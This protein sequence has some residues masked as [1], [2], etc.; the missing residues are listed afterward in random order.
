MTA[1]GDEILPLRSNPLNHYQMTTEQLSYSTWH[2]VQNAIEKGHAT[3]RG[4]VAQ[5][6]AL[7][8]EIFGQSSFVE[9][10]DTEVQRTYNAIFQFLNP[11]FRSK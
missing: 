10:V 2:D 11:Q 6:R 7:K 4:V 3:L 8:R 5:H 9:W 1:Q